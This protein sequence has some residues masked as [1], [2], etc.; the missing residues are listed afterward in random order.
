MLTATECKQSKNGWPLGV[1]K[2]RLGFT[3]TSSASTLVRLL[4][5]KYGGEF[6]AKQYD[7]PGEHLSDIWQS[8]RLS[9]ERYG[10]I[11]A[12]I[13]GFTAAQIHL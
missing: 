2:H 10:Q 13:E 1:Y 5:A 9:M 12:Y 4:K 8:A 11:R 7:A 6:E 3:Y